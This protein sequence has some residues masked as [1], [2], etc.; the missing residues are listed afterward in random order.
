MGCSLIT[1]IRPYLVVLSSQLMR[2][3]PD[4]DNSVP[5]EKKLDAVHPLKTVLDTMFKTLVSEILEAKRMEDSG[6]NGLW[7]QIYFSGE[8]KVSLKPREGKLCLG[9]KL[10]LRTLSR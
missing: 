2:I 7:L 8:F 4:L 3:S 5:D 10:S 9:S 6:D 1:V